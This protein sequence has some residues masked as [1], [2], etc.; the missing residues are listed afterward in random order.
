MGLFRLWSFVAYRR[1]PNK[2]AN[3]L[4]DTVGRLMDRRV[5]KIHIPLFLART[6]ARL[7]RPLLGRRGI[8]AEQV[9]RL[10]EDKAFT[11]E[12]AARDLGLRP[13]SVESGLRGLLSLLSP[14]S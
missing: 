1:L 8:S 5:W 4:I 6:A 11:H 7:T 2:W 14:G 12:D 10:N 13:R 9:M 3:E